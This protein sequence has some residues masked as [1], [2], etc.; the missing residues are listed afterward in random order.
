M[1]PDP[2]TVLD[3]LPVDGGVKADAW[4]AFQSSAGPSHFKSLMDPLALPDEAKADLWDLKFGGSE[5]L[6]PKPAATKPVPA[7]GPPKP[8]QVQRV[9]AATPNPPTAFTATEPEAPETIA[10]QIGQLGTGLRRVVMFPRGHGQPSTLPDSTAVTHDAFGNTYAYRPDL[11][12]KG[13]IH[14]AAKNNALTQILGGPRGM[15]SPDKSLLPPETV[16]VTGR[17]ADGTE[18]QSTATD[19]ASLPLTVSAT[20]AV[21]PPGGS[22]SVEPT[23]SVVMRRII[24]NQP[25]TEAV[26]VFANAPH[27]VKSATA[28]IL[29]RRLAG[30]TMDP[31]TSAIAARYFRQPV[32]VPVQTD[33]GSPQPLQ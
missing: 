7:T 10:I 2:T 14:T 27:E 18:A 13:D 4:D 30:A 23:A 20:H 33:L 19:S 26:R 21:T 17:S 1:T 12:K 11:I 28:G 9:S 24:Q 29:R 15:G 22:V 5:P 31:A 6:M 8:N 16:T 25:I 3:P 32:P